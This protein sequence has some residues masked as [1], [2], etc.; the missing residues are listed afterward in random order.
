VKIEEERLEV[1]RKERI[2]A[3]M[4]FNCPHCNQS[5]KMAEDMLGQTIECPSCRKAIRASDSGAAAL[6]PHDSSDTKDCPFCGEQILAEARKCRYC[7]EFLDAAARRQMKNRSP[8]ASMPVSP[9]LQSSSSERT[10]YD[11]HPSMFRSN[12]LGFVLVLVLC[13]VLI[14]LVIL[15]FWWLKTLGTKLTVTNKRSILRKGVLSKSTTEVLHQDV[16]N[17]QIN[18]T[19]FQRICGVGSIGISSAGQAGI[20][21]QAQGMPTPDKIKQIID[22]YRIG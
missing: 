14:G 7:G 5:L 20:E 10:E 4:K 19:F 1:M 8:P 9:V 12:P 6:P 2:M 22:K 16:R 11:S 15:L 17:I 18:Q 21:I 13:V 3:G